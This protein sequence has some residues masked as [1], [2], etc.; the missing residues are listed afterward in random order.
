MA[1]AT[2]TLRLAT[3]ILILPERNPVVLAKELATLDHSRRAG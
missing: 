2:T 3:G 1:R